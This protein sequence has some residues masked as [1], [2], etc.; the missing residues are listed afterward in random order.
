MPSFDIVSRTDMSEV[1]N[2]L[3]AMSK[4]IG[5]RFDF[6]GSKSSVELKDENIVLIA[7]DDLKLKQLH[8]LLK[9]HLVRRQVEFGALDMKTPEKASGGTLRQNI[10][11]K[12]GL[13]QEVAK[14]ITKAIKD[15]KAKVQASIQGDEVRVNGKK[16]DD[17]QEAIALVKG[18]PITLPLQFVNF[19]D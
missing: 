15:A 8:E 10:T 14:Q 13:D 1:N 16:R 6:K 5:Q 9:T 11:I 12:Q 4:E 7:D 17:L 19:R 18:L 2:A 3:V